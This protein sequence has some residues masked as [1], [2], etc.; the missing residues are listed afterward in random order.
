MWEPRH[1]AWRCGSKPQDG[2]NRPSGWNVKRPAIRTWGQYHSRV[3]GS[4]GGECGLLRRRHSGKGRAVPDRCSSICAICCQSMVDTGGWFMNEIS[5]SN[6]IKNVLSLQV[7]REHDGSQEAVRM[8][9][10]PNAA[11]RD[12]LSSLKPRMHSFETVWWI[13]CSRFK[14]CATV[15]DRA[16]RHLAY[17]G[18]WA[19]PATSIM[20]PIA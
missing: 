9:R 11:I 10:A 17:D 3:I 5:R 12:R 15:P 13:S 4:T 8:E 14:R 2:R 1:T 7:A 16:C 18:L 20:T 6:G 19:F